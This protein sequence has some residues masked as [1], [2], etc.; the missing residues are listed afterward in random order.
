MVRLDVLPREHCYYCQ[1]IKRHGT[2]CPRSIRC[3]DCGA[4]P[5]KGCMR[6]SGHAANGLHDR[7]I[8]E[9]EHQDQANGIEYPEPYQH[10]E[11]RKGS[12]DD[13]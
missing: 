9:A 2:I 12:C 13:R 8:Y 5:T 10:P 1:C 6:P 3:P 11:F 4:A 7:R